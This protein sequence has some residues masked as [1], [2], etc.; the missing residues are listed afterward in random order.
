MAAA[1]FA[2]AAGQAEAPKSAAGSASGI[3]WGLW[4]LVNRLAW[5]S[6]RTIRTTTIEALRRLLPLRLRRAAAEP[7]HRRRVRATALRFGVPGLGASSRRSRFRPSCRADQP[8]GGPCVG[9]DCATWRPTTCC[10]GTVTTPRCSTTRSSRSIKEEG[11]SPQHAGD[12]RRRPVQS[13]RDHAG[14]LGQGCLLRLR[15]ADQ[16][17][18]PDQRRRGGARR[19]IPDAKVEVR[20]VTRKSDSQPAGR[21]VRRLRVPRAVRSGSG[22]GAPP[23]LSRALFRGRRAAFAGRPCRCLPASRSFTGE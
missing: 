22:T 1:E 12:A 23:R 13:R 9:V 21:D 16:T 6:P 3:G 20:M 15:R 17:A 2:E 19:P 10:S 7:R 14:R 5:S 4:D 8:A 11:L 18:P